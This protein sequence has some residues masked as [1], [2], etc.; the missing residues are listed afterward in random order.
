MTNLLSDRSKELL[1]KGNSFDVIRYFFTLSIIIVH[2]CY[3]S[4]IEVF[5]PISGATGVKVFFIISGFLIFYSHI[6]KQSIK[7]YIEKRIRRILPPYISVVVLCTIGGLFITQLS[8]KD[9]IS[10]NETYK[11]LIANLGFLNFLQPTLPGVFESN[12]ITAVNGSLWTMK[13]EVMFYISVPF[14]FWLLK[15]YNK[16]C[17]MIIIFLIAAIYDIYFTKLY[18]QTGNNFYLLIRKQFGSQLIYFYSGTFILLYFDIFIKYLKYFFPLAIIISYFQYDCFLLNYIEPLALATIIIGCAY[19]LKHLNYIRKY[20][21]ISYGMYLYHFP[22]TQAV[23]Y[24][25]EPHNTIY[26][27]FILSLLLTIIVSL[28]SWFLIEKPIIIGNKK[29]I[30][31]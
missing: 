11:Y 2:F 14:I 28:I 7:Y 12:P 25:I 16:L 4:D 19:N 22:I 15:R 17:I 29:N 8:I 30:N 9:Y 20:D 13:V 6:E 3:L 21:N 18:E 31:R 5:W 10:D 27:A 1:N 23:V 26:I 24:Y